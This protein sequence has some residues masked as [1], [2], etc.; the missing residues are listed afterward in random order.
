MRLTVIRSIFALCI[1][2]PLACGEQV[3]VRETESKCGNSIVE[4]GEQCDDANDVNTV[5]FNTFPNTIGDNTGNTYPIGK[6]SSVIVTFSAKKSK[7]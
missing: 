5:P 7:T 1:M 2:L 6:N 4:T 3:V